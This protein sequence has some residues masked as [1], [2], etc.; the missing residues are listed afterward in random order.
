MDFRSGFQG[1]GKS[2]FK[3][4]IKK[5]RVDQVS[6]GWDRWFYMDGIDG[7]ARMIDGFTW[8]GSMV[9]HR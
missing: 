6:H 7:F 9:L 2:G 1:F 5:T 3:D 8:M 4:W